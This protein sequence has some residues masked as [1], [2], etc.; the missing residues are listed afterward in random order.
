MEEI[1]AIIL[2]S[3]PMGACY[4]ALLAIDAPGAKTRYP[5]EKNNYRLDPEQDF[6]FPEADVPPG[7]Y[8][9]N[10]YPTQS[11]SYAIFQSSPPMCRITSRNGV[12]KKPRM[13]LWEAAKTLP[14]PLAPADANDQASEG[15]ATREELALDRAQDATDFLRHRLGLQV[16]LDTQRLTRE[17]VYT[18]EIVEMQQLNRAY[19]EELVAAQQDSARRW[20]TNEEQLSNTTAA[21]LKLVD[22]TAQLTGGYAD[23]LAQRIERIRNPP[24][25]PPPPDYMGGFNTLTNATKDVLINFINRNKPALALQALP[26]GSLP[27]PGDATQSGPGAPDPLLGVLESLLG[28]ASPPSVTGEADRI[29]KSAAAAPKPATTDKKTESSAEMDKVREFIRKHFR[30]KAELDAVVE[31]LVPELPSKS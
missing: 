7:T 8:R 11:P 25:P 13:T 29:D 14:G 12:I 2:K 15:Q 16:Q 5:G 9:V 27:L 24:P 1:K 30:S 20:R 18:R 28:S 26:Q 6:E 21:M 3:K 19:R 31:Q 10:Y 22:R 4:Y 17:Q 23:V